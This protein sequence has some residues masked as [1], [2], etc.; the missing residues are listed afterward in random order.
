MI[1]RPDDVVLDVVLPKE[2]YNELINS[3]KTYRLIKMHIGYPFADMEYLVYELEKAE[4]DIYVSNRYF[5]P[6]YKHH[7]VFA[8]LWNLDIYQYVLCKWGY[9]I[10]YSKAK[11]SWYYSQKNDRY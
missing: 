1:Y 5:V 11:N 2:E 4:R 7:K 3:I 8:S 10:Y 6:I 9:N